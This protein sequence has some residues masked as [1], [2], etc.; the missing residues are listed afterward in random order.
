MTNLERDDRGNNHFLEGIFFCTI[1][2]LQ[3]KVTFL[4]FLPLIHT[5]VYFLVFS[6]C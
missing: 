3:D 4:S 5:P 6:P 1:A 2:Y